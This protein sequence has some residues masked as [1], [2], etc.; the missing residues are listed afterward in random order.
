M[1][2]GAVPVSLFLHAAIA[3]LLVFGLPISLPQ[4]EEQAVAVDLVPPEPPA[5]AKDEPP[6][7]AEKP[8][9]EQ[10]QKANPEPPPPARDTAGQESAP[11]V[12]QPV[13]QFGEKDMGPREALRGN[14]A[15]EGSASPA[16]QRDARKQDLAKPPAVAAIPA[17]GEALQPTA[18]AAPATEPAEAAKAQGAVE[19]RE[20]KTLFSQAATGNSTSATAMDD[21]PRDV[22]AGRLC[23]TE[24]REQL[25]HA[26]PPYFPELLPSHRLEDDTVIEITRTAFRASRLWYDLSYRCEVDPEVTKVVAFAF[27][28]GE[29]IPRSEWRRRGLPSE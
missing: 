18:S 14:S 9:P 19:L 23:V 16:A 2:R 25:L 28:V 13:F 7:P 10:T 6:P 3:A 20:A 29:P 12:L 26:L 22:R 8:K 24:L 15:K 1:F 27:H 11:A 17:P 5:E 4:T 21:V